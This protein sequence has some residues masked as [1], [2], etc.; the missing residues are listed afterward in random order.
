MPPVHYAN[1]PCC[2]PCIPLA[3]RLLTVCDPCTGCP[4][5]VEVCVPACAGEPCVSGRPTL[6]GNG[7]VRFD[8]P[9]YAV[10]I[11]FMRCGDLKVIYH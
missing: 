2:D 6:F 11:R 8:W 7:L 1:Q 3:T 4:L 10:T 5:G 9:G